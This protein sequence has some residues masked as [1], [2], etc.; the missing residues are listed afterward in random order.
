[1]EKRENNGDCGERSVDFFR[2]PDYDKKREIP[3]DVI[4][5]PWRAAALCLYEFACVFVPCAVFQ[6]VLAARERKSGYRRGAGRFLLVFLLLFYL[7][8]VLALTGIG[9]VW[10]IG[11][12]PPHLIPP[13]E[14]NLLP[15]RA[16]VPQWQIEAE[17]AVLFVP[18]GFLLPLIWRRYRSMGRTAAAG[19]LLSAAIELSQLFNRRFT[20]IDDLIMNTLGAVLGWALWCLFRALLRGERSA[21]EE[22]LSGR[23][24]AARHEGCLLLVLAFAGV[25]FL[26]DP[27]IVG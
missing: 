2:L 24:F 6:A 10:D 16:L 19:F 3:K 18:L 22:L 11:R 17:N 8:L 13:H 15:F 14:I 20:D 23:S 4:H 7:S 27:W 1:M 21:P 12:Y 5:L 9:T 26:F 25:F